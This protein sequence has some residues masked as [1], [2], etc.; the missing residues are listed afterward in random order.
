[1]A[2]QS[3]AY[4]IS[5]HDLYN[6]FL[7]CPSNCF[8]RMQH[9][10]LTY[11]VVILSLMPKL[12]VT[13]SFHPITTRLLKNGRYQS[14]SW[15]NLSWVKFSIGLC[16]YKLIFVLIMAYFANKPQLQTTI[17]RQADCCQQDYYSGELF[18]IW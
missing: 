10:Y 13:E 1:M 2:N 12:I 5:Y 9:S 14:L 6:L 17:L 7:Y 18:L 11:R 8:T 4:L 3:Y 15:W 16:K